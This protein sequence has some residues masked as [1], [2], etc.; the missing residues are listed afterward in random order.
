V[1][2]ELCTA[3]IIEGWAPHSDATIW[4]ALD[5]KATRQTEERLLFGSITH[6]NFVRDG[7]T[8]LEGTLHNVGHTAV[9]GALAQMESAAWS[10]MF[11]LHHANIDR[12]YEA[13]LQIHGPEQIEIDFRLEN[14]KLAHCTRAG[15]AK[16][17]VYEQTLEPF[18]LPSGEKLKNEH[19]FDTRRLGYVYDDLPHSAQFAISH[20]LQAQAQADAMLNQQLRLADLQLDALPTAHSTIYVFLE[21]RRGGDRAKFPFTANGMPAPAAFGSRASGSAVLF[22]EGATTDVI[23]DVDESYQLWA[24][25]GFTHDDLAVIMWVVSDTQVYTRQDVKLPVPQWYTKVDKK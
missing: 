9:G 5:G 20:Q 22:N 25:Q 18:K 11:W 24:S 16:C 21:P 7:R 10:P 6:R 14:A 8:T 23:I 13:F 12:L 3:E 19:L 1:H 2:S 4:Q 15:Q 17:N